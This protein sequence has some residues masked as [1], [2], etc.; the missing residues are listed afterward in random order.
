M[1]LCSVCSTAVILYPMHPLPAA[2]L[3]EKAT[4]MLVHDAGEQAQFLGIC[5][6][7]KA[8]CRFPVGCQVTAQK[9]E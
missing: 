8:I 3:Y 2:E 1:L 4:G 5:F 6:L 7:I 9:T